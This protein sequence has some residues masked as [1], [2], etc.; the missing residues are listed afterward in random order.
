MHRFKALHVPAHAP[1]EAWAHGFCNSIKPAGANSVICEHDSV[2]QTGKQQLCQGAPDPAL[3]AH[4]E[5]R[6][7]TNTAGV[8]VAALRQPLRLSGILVANDIQVVL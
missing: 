1:V 6:Y 3:S 4:A 7:L 5:Q 2:C 8:R